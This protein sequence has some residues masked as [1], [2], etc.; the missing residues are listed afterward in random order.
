[1]RTVNPVIAVLFLLR[2]ASADW[3]VPTDAT[4][5]SPKSV[6][7]VVMLDE[8]PD[9]AGKPFLIIGII[10]PP[11]YGWG[12]FGE[13]ANAAR[14]KAALHGADAILVD[15]EHHQFKAIVWK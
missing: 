12:S 15:R 3:Y 8:I 5:R 13:M 9:Q 4:H 6:E 1:M 2:C 7:S 11:E 10:S 14:T